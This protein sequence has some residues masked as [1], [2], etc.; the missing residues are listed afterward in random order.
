MSI[1]RIATVT[2]TTSVTFSGP[3]VGDLLIILAST[4]DETI[5]PVAPTGF[6]T[7]ILNSRVGAYAV[8]FY[9]TS[10]GTETTVAATNALSMV[11]TIY[12]SSTGRC[13][14]GAM[15]STNAATTSIAFP[16]ITLQDTGGSSWVVLALNARAAETA[17]P[18]GYTQRGQSV[19][20]FA[21]ATMYDSN[22]GKTSYTSV[23]ASFAAATGANAITL[24]IREITTTTIISTT[25]FNNTNTGTL[26][27]VRKGD[28][29]I[30]NFYN[31]ASATLP[32][33]PTGWTSIATGNSAGNT[34][35]NAN[36]LAYKIA[37]GDETSVVTTGGAFSQVSVLRGKWPLTIGASAVGGAAA[38]PAIIPALTLQD[39]GGQSF[40]WCGWGIQNGTS[41]AGTAPS[42]LTTHS[43]L[44]NTAVYYA[45]DQ[46]SWPGSTKAIT[47]NGYRVGI[48]EIKEVTPN[49]TANG[50]T[51]TVAAS[52]IVAATPARA[53]TGHRA[54][55]FLFL[56]G[57][58]SQL[59][60]GWIKLYGTRRGL[61]HLTSASLTTT[62]GGAASAFATT[63]GS[64][65]GLFN[66]AN[67]PTFYNWYANGAYPSGWVAWDFGVGNEQDV[68]AYS[69]SPYTG[70]AP[71]SWK[72]QYCDDVGTLTNWVD[73]HTAGPAIQNSSSGEYGNFWVGD[74]DGHVYNVAD[75]SG[76]S[77]HQ[78]WRV[79]WPGG[80]SPTGSSDLG[81]QEIKWKSA[82]DS[83]LTAHW[84]ANRS[85]T[86]VAGAF[87]PSLVYDRNTATS[88][89][90]AASGTSV[91]QSWTVDLGEKIVLTEV[92]LT[93]YSAT[94]YRPTVLVEWSDDGYAWTT[95]LTSTG[96]VG[97]GAGSTTALTIT[98]AVNGTATGSIV[99][100]AASL[101]AGAA[102]VAATGQGG[103]LPAAFSLVAGSASVVLNATVNGD[104]ITAAASIIAGSASAAAGGTANG[105]TI[106]AAFSLVDGVA[107]VSLDATAPG[108][109]IVVASSLVEGS[110]AAVQNGSASG[111]ILGLTGS[112]VAGT[113]SVSVSAPGAVL[114]AASSLVDGVASSSVT[115]QGS[116]L[117]IAASLIPGE[118]EVIV[119]TPAGLIAQASI[120]V[121]VSG[122]ARG[123]ASVAGQVVE[124]GGIVVPGEATGGAN[125]SGKI[126]PFAASVVA[127]LASA[128]SIGE[129]ALFDRAVTLIPGSAAGAA[130]I[131]GAV[132]PFAITTIISGTAMGVSATPARTL[133]LAAI[134][135]AGLASAGT[136]STTPAQLV[137][138]TTSI[139]RGD[140]AGDA[141]VAGQLLTR[142][143]SLVEGA[144][145]ADVVAV[146]EAL[147]EAALSLISGEAY[148]VSA[149]QGVVLPF[150]ARVAQSGVATGE[151]NALGVSLVRALTLIPG[152]ANFNFG[153]PGDV[154]V[155]LPQDVVMSVPD[156]G[157][158]LF[159]ER[160]P[161]GLV[162]P[163]EVRSMVVGPRTRSAA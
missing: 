130:N 85:S 80:Q 76:A 163:T 112:L 16:A 4:W 73:I 147:P 96:N 40:V 84:G 160:D 140:A 37:D 45:E 74:N 111:A 29:L 42:G 82:S 141:N 145:G 54:Y 47:F 61:N 78:F 41:N 136:N 103:V 138:T 21:V 32:G 9:K 99:P 17:D 57:Q 159:A 34:L 139:I 93:H 8:V 131:S 118:A 142:A 134:I 20:S 151:A 109:T 95:A 110:A 51:V 105:D 59:D 28:L 22:A 153:T 117:P 69:I 152:N 26:T 67:S 121:A 48:V 19:V 30:G 60:L 50:A 36:R 149:A 86:R 122:V 52:L 38:D 25:L 88:G 125:V 143:L 162:V 10:D 104:T 62:A 98:S 79:R 120:A 68:K 128:G 56:S 1:S 55:R 106:T 102:S 154:G 87:R 115:L 113:P 46:T 49:G 158:V 146:G 15:A 157:R 97:K 92:E 43:N 71:W 6:A 127:G 39:T 64:A 161:R 83:D 66:Y 53:F 18:V 91:D 101:V 31:N 13:S 155:P 35:Q 89:F 33:L 123:A 108:A 75:T 5:P 107:S 72:F 27:N 144:A 133:V 124:V 81:Y 7:A 119:Y 3:Q 132:L 12:R 65:A 63:G 58:N 70:Y 90:T 129:G 2:G 137:R 150:I 116:I 23:S 156:D 94:Y 114:T 11:G 126:V 24:E 135:E 44:V 100:V 14:I 148:G 77:G